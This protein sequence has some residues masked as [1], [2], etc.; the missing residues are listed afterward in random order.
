MRHIYI[1]NKITAHV[2]ICTSISCPKGYVVI[3]KQEAIK[4]LG[5]RRAGKNRLKRMIKE[6]KG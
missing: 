1:Q 2:L 4:R 5:G 6:L 3:S